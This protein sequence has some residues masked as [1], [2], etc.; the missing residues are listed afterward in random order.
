MAFVVG[1][2]MWLVGISLIWFAFQ[3]I[4]YPA[5]GFPLCVQ[6]TWQTVLIL[7]G[8]VLIVGVFF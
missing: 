1:S 8:F 3:T 7:L 5:S 2:V 6:R 4:K